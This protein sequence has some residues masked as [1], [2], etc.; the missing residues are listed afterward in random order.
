VRAKLAY[1]PRDVWLY[2]LAAQW[3]R[4]SQQEAFVGRAG[5]VGDEPGSALVGA[6]LVR[7]LMGLCF[8]IE[9]RYAPYSK[10]FGT[11]FA[12]LACAPRL[13]PLFRGALR[14]GDWREREE[15]LCPAYEAVAELF[16][17][18]GLTPPSEPSVRRYYDRPFRVIFAGRFAEA[19][20]NRI[21]DDGVRAIVRRVGLVGSV[22]Q[23]TDNTDVKE[24]SEGAA[25]LRA[26]YE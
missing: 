20:A 12:G 14:A 9:R 22:D 21:E 23:I 25:R 17:E 7:D 2:L 18:L 8:L 15:W 26:L 24:W 11:A 1:Y 3:Q 5:E 19:A 4:V 6:A 13:L 16:N 10:W